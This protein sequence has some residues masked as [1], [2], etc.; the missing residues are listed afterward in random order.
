MKVEVM[1]L[2]CMLFGLI[3]FVSIAHANCQV[4]NAGIGGNTSKDLLKRIDKDVL[5]Q[6]PDL[7]ILMVGTNDMLNS[8]K[9]LS[10]EEYAANIEEIVRKLKTN[11]AEVVLMTSLPVDSVYLFTRHNRSN[12]TEPPN[13]K[14]DSVGQIVEGI[15][16][17]HKTYF[18]DLNAVFKSRNLPQHNQD[19]FIKNPRN[20]SKTDGVHPT[21]LGYHLIASQVFFF[22]KENE[23][24]KSDKKIICF[25]DSITFGGGEENE[26][27]YPSYLNQFIKEGHK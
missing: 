8:R 10:Y 5:S 23:L 20:S 6:N 14:I 16:I 17:K 9:M 1:K 26:R 24:I 7:V 15:A 25:G 21:S 3:A 12:F 19:L 11:G 13:A 2:R 18:F 22:L 27:N 4:I